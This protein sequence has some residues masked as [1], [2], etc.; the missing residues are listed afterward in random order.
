MIILLR[1]LFE[2]LLC[3]AFARVC[4]GSLWSLFNILNPFELSL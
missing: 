4:F 1:V 2:D 3:S